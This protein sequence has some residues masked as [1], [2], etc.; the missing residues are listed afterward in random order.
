MSSVGFFGQRIAEQA[1]KSFPGRFY[2]LKPSAFRVCD[3]LSFG[4]TESRLLKALI[5]WVLG[6]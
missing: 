4:L 3:S 1:V 6:Q 5:K 2:F